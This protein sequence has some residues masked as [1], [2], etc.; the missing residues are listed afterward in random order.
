MILTG[1]KIMDAGRRQDLV[2]CLLGILVEFIPFELP[3]ET[4]AALLEEPTGSW[5]I[6]CTTSITTADNNIV[7]K[8]PSLYWMWQE[9][10][11]SC[12]LNFLAQEGFFQWGTIEAFQWTL[13]ASYDNSQANTTVHG[14]ASNYLH[15]GSQTEFRRF[16]PMVLASDDQ[17]GVQASPPSSTM[18]PIRSFWK[19]ASLKSLCVEFPVATLMGAL[20]KDSSST[21]WRLEPLA[22]FECGKVA[23]IGKLP[24]TSTEHIQVAKIIG[25]LEAWKTPQVLWSSPPGLGIHESFSVDS[26]ADIFRRAFTFLEDEERSRPTSTSGTAGG[27]AA[28]SKSASQR[29]SNNES[30][31]E[32]TAGSPTHRRIDIKKSISDSLVMTGGLAATGA[33]FVTPIGAAVS[34]AAIGVKDGVAAAARKGQDSRNGEG[35]KFGDVTRGIV[36]S[37]K[38]RKSQRQARAQQQTDDLIFTGEETPSANSRDDEHS[39]LEINKSRYVGVVGSSV[40][41]AVG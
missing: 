41:A 14:S 23:L 6:P 30:N 29:T 27:M 12:C 21:I 5:V 9:E 19:I 17:H 35:Y 11:G 31:S 40:G 7:W 22:V 13:E 24:S 26:L 8:Q 15:G 33:S 2:E 18:T 4:R 3:D 38:D 36:T 20:V 10:T 25:L 16:E 1:D 28:S 39:F 37:I 32:T 34:V